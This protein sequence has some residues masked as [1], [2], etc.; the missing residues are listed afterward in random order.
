MV[1]DMERLVAIAEQVAACE[2]IT[3]L[4]NAPS[5]IHEPGL[6]SSMYRD[7]SRPKPS[8]RAHDT[9]VDHRADHGR[10]LSWIRSEA[11]TRRVCLARCHSEIRLWSW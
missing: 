10:Q 1:G 4:I 6:A 9:N 5:S 7:Y 11:Q 2:T 8:R 3:R